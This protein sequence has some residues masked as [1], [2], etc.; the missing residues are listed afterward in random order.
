MWID[1][2]QSILMKSVHLKNTFVNMYV[3]VT[4]LAAQVL[5]SEGEKQYSAMQC[6]L[7]QNDGKIQE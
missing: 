5:P 3:Q 2:F 6:K 4:K 7:C 1:R